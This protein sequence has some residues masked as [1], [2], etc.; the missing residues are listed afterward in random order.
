M[1]RVI[2]RAGASDER[3]RRIASADRA[4]TLACRPGIARLKRALNRRLFPA[5][6]E[7]AAARPLSALCA[8]PASSTFV[9]RILPFGSPDPDG[10]MA[11]PLSLHRVP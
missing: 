8:D 10:I 11:S 5:Q 9:T 7:I 6:A 3:D 4:V 2:T 1:A